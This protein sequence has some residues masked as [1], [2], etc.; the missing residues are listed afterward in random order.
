MII[1]SLTD[2]LNFSIASIEAEKKL[3][4]IG[5]KSTI[6]SRDGLNMHFSANLYQRID[7]IELRKNREHIVA[8]TG[9]VVK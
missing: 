3:Y 5:S 8:R 7:C 9:T 6:N 4:R 2:W 1:L